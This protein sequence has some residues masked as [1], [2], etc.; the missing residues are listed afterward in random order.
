M[1]LLSE[2]NS[3]TAEKK[4]LVYDTDLGYLVNLYVN[5]KFFYRQ[6]VT[7]LDAAEDLAESFVL[8]KQQ[9]LSE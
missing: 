2:H 3:T 5:G 9:F 1:I 7:T 4:A 6:T 8:E